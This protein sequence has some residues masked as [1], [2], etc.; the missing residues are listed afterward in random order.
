MPKRLTR[1]PSEI[2]AMRESGQM[3]AAILQMLKEQTVPNIS[4]KEL[5]EIAAKELRSLGGAPTFLGYYGF[6]DIICIS[7]NNEVVHGDVY[8]RQIYM[9]NSSG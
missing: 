7:I 3:L 5:A 1:T 2:H 4:T 6:P 8:K 9:S